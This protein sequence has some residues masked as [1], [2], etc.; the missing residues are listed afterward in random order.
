MLRTELWS[1]YSRGWLDAGH[2]VCS[3][4]AGGVPGG[5]PCMGPRDVRCAWIWLRT[6]DTKEER[7]AGKAISPLNCQR[8]LSAIRSS[9][10]CR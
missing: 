8:Q 6:K 5:A 7:D 2:I 4:V 10:H 9:T 1:A 3:V